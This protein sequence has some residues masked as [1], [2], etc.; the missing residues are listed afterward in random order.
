MKIIFLDIDGVMNSEVDW[1]DDIQEKRFDIS[2]RC[3]EL[4][5]KLIEN[6]YAKVVISSTWRNT[7]KIEKM[8]LI[9]KN[10]GFK[11]EIID[12]TPRLGVDTLRGNEIYKWIFS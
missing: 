1:R 11:G 8:R 6:T 10:K 12:Y 4:L 5:N 2:E 9:F 3:I 7:V